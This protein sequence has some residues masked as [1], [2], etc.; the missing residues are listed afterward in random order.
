MNAVIVKGDNLELT[1]ALPR[2]MAQCQEALIGWC[3]QKIRTIREEINDLTAAVDSA[4]KHKWA[5]SALKRQLD[6]AKK[7]IIYYGKV[8]TALKAGYCI[9]PN[10][11]IT[12]FAIR[13]NRSI[14]SGNA[15]ESWWARFEQHPTV[16]PEGQGEYKNPLPLVQRDKNT[17]VDAAG[18]TKTKNISYPVG[19]TP[20]M[21]FPI[22][23][24]KPQI[25][26]AT[27]AALKLHVFDALG[28]C[29]PERRRDP[30]IIGAIYDGSAPRLADKRVSFLIAWHLDTQ[31]L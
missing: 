26:E 4:I 18:K 7:R 27:S 8:M 11:P 23:M 20:E 16:L 30:M 5:V 12:G 1:A 22:S 2:E 19:W 6:K 21:E 15:V 29:P 31:V 3:Q 24:A 9:V 14:P 28:I 13:T 17:E 25:I 10:F